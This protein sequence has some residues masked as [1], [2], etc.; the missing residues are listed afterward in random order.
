M[1]GVEQ[2]ARDLVLQD[3]APNAGFERS[4]HINIFLMLG[5]KY[6]LGLGKDFEISRAASRPLRVGMLIS[7]ITTSG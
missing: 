4:G 5:Q 7:M 1:H 2:I 3:I 6:G